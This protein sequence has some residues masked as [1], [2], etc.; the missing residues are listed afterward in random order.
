MRELNLFESALHAAVPTQPRF[1]ARAALVPQL[2]EAARRRKTIREA[3]NGSAAAPTL[4]T[5]AGSQGGTDERCPL[6]PLV[7]AGLALGRRTCGW[8]RVQPSIRSGSPCR[9]SRPSTPRRRPTTGARRSSARRRGTGNTETG[10]SIGAE[11]GKSAVRTPARASEEQSKATEGVRPR[12]AG[13]RRFGLGGLTP[14]VVTM[15]RDW[16]QPRAPKP[17]PGYSVSSG[18]RARPESIPHP[19]PTGTPTATSS[20][21]T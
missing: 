3:E 5:R 2:D 1:G 17:G 16:P 9:N 11:R 15:R 10:R 20:K 6:I 18:G 13:L 19:C 4:E 14:P 21:V 8:G 7:L 12:G